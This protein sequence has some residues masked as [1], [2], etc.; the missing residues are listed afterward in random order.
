MKGI[1]GGN[2]SSLGQCFSIE[3]RELR[4]GMG[5]TASGDAKGAFY[6]GREEG[7]GQGGIQ[8]VR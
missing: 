5:A 6:R 2:S 4:V 1:S 7:S 3:E 8:S